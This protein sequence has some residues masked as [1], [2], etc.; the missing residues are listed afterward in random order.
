MTTIIKMQRLTTK[1]CVALITVLT[2][3][4]TRPIPTNHR[5]L[6]VPIATSRRHL[7]TLSSPK[8]MFLQ[9]RLFNHRPS[10]ILLSSHSLIQWIIRTWVKTLEQPMVQGLILE[11]F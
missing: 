4:R 11:S 7:S 10:R 5:T 8:Q 1:Q 9:R 6:S 3:A 2:Q